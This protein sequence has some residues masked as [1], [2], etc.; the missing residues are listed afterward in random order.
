MVLERCTTRTGYVWGWN[1]C[2]RLLCGN[3]WRIIGRE[4]CLFSLDLN[5]ASPTKITPGAPFT[6]GKSQKARQPA[7][8]FIVLPTG[9]RGASGPAASTPT[10]AARFMTTMAKRH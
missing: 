9:G 7:A 5:K 10:S 8:A 2:S 4:A 1:A 6:R 3:W